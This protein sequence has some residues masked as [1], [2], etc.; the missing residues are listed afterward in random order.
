VRVIPRR[1]TN[2]NHEEIH[3]TA[4][5]KFIP[6][7]RIKSAHRRYISSVENRATPVSLKVYARAVAVMEAPQ[8]SLLV[9]AAKAWLA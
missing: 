8:D 9:K 3:M 4:T 5:D 6:G 2:E 7:K 1:S